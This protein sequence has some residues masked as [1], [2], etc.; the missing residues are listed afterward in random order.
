[1]IS[2]IIKARLDADDVRYFANDNISSYINPEEHDLLIDE[3]AEKFES[4]LPTHFSPLLRTVPL[5]KCK[6]VL[7]PLNITISSFI[8]SLA[9][10]L[11]LFR[12]K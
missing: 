9:L 5:D 4:V 6:T 8:L 11:S 10:N 2:D 1:M 7:L 3:V 12:N